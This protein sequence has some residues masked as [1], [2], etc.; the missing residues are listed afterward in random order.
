MCIRKF[1]C[2]GK[3]KSLKNYFGTKHGVSN[4]NSW[5]QGTASGLMTTMSLLSIHFAKSKM[6]AEKGS[7]M[8]MHWRWKPI[9]LCAFFYI[10]L[11]ISTFFFMERSCKKS[12]QPCVWHAG[13][14]L[15]NN[16]H[17]ILITGLKKMTVE[18]KGQNILLPWFIAKGITDG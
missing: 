6:S 5:F 18:K 12:R 4:P 13:L 16:D 1:W 2:D 15:V 9:L 3:D 11:A 14:F 7:H 17:L 10:S 8:E